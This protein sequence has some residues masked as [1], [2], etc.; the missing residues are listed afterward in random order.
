M[1][2][3]PDMLC[4]YLETDQ[5]GAVSW[6]LDWI[7]KSLEGVEVYQVAEEDAL[8]RAE[9]VRS[10][11]FRNARDKLDSEPPVYIRIWAGLLG[12]WPSVTN[13]G[14]RVLIQARD[15][16]MDQMGSLFRAKIS[17]SNDVMI[18]GPRESDKE[19]ARFGFLVGDL[20]IE[21]WMDPVSGI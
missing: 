9:M 13:G 7:L 1:F 3:D 20:C 14:C 21:S 18:R 19:Y 16:F 5:F 8:T 17:W 6:F 15:W 11:R 10:L 4:W 12:L 2:P